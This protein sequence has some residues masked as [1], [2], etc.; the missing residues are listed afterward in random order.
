MLGNAAGHSS[1]A[2]STPRQDAGM[3]RT[4]IKANP[5]IRQEGCRQGLANSIPGHGAGPVALWHPAGRAG[6]SPGDP[7]GMLGRGLV[8]GGRQDAQPLPG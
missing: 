4:L 1:A 2:S 3:S 7:V 6:H 8:A 5:R